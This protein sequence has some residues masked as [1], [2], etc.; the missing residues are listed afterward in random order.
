[1]AKMWNYVLVD[2]L[3]WVF[4]LWSVGLPYEAFLAWSAFHGVKLEVKK[5][6]SR[7]QYRTKNL[8]DSSCLVFQ[9]L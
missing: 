3:N 2:D 4:S 8:N 1:M 9:I 7:H 5:S 6:G